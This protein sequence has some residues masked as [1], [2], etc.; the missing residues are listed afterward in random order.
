MIY[1]KINFRNTA[2]SELMLGT[3]QL[4]MNYG[5]SNRK[6]QPSP[7]EGMTILQEAVNAG[8]NTLD[9]AR[10]YGSSEEII[11]K[12]LAERSVESTVNVITKFSLHP[13]IKTLEKAW[14]AV[15]ESV[16][17]SISVLGVP[18]LNGCLFHRSSKND[19]D[20]AGQFLPEIFS[21]LKEC[22]LVDLV[23]F[24]AFFPN[25]LEYVATVPQ[26]DLIQVPFNLFDQR[27]LRNDLLSKV[28]DGGKLIIARSV[29]LQGLFF[30]EDARLPESLRTAIPYLQRLRDFCHLNNITIGTLVLSFV[31]DHPDIDC[32]VIGVE[33][34]NQM[35][36]LHGLFSSPRLTALQMN[37]LMNEFFI[38]NELV[39]TPALWPQVH[40]KKNN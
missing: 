38:E 12:F 37:D 11:G 9:T 27:I 19:L 17:T 32:M 6:G 1:N 33:N 31:R 35:Q 8:I 24:S 25:D 26:I 22:E 18:K 13:E 36:E 20:I 15:R 21:R 29:F 40:T 39:L 10:S 14:Q 30:M 2:F 34:V 5:I 3:V 7:E 28:R 4:G 16:L 23:G